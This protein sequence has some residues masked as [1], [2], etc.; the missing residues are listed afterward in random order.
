MAVGHTPVMVKEVLELL[1]PKPEGIYLDATLGAGGHAGA[2]LE[3]T[4]GKIQ[5]IGIDQDPQALQLAKTTLE[6]FGERI[7]GVEN[8]FGNI[9]NV[10]ADLHI[11]RLDG[12]VADL[13]L[14]SMQLSEPARGFSFQSEGPLD[15]RMGPGIS[16][17]AKDL[18]ENLDEEALANLLY[19]Y[20]EERLSRKIAR[21]IREALQ[22]GS[23]ETTRDLADLVW[24]CYPPKARH[25][26]IHPATR[27]FQA[28]RIA[29][30]GELDQLKKFL[31]EAPDCL[32][33]EGVLA[34]ISYH[35][36]EDRL[37][38]HRFKDLAQ[39]EFEV[40]TKKPLTASDEEREQN[41]RSR[42]AKLRGLRR[43]EF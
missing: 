27:V 26:R 28:L 5:L 6:N 18:L 16:Q 32:N 19:Q 4:E 35:S 24:H 7:V 14:S 2:L 34:V 33:T 36:L 13:G 15:M 30:N 37:V 41:P 31:E 1:Q 11:E 22:E 9:R 10:L 12:I 42:S 43:K 29:V 39:E 20:G 3:K 23:L 8:N 17:T 21:R 25:G 38:K 40:L